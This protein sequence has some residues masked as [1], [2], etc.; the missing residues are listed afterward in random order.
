[1]NFKDKVALITGASRGIGAAIA[2]DLASH[3]CNI[4]INYNN[5]EEE[6]NKLKDKIE[7]EFKVKV[8]II[9]ADITKENEII[10][11][12]NNVIKEFGKI[13]ILVNNAGIA[14]DSA[15]EDKNI[16]SF[17][18]I[19]D[20]NLI[21]P[22]LISREVAKYMVSQK[23]GSIINISSTNGL[24]AYY[25]YSLD[26]DASKAGLISL[27][28]NLSEMFAPYI[29]VNALAPG[30]VNTDMNKE[31]DEEYIKEEEK[32]IYLNRFANPDEIAKV[33]TFLASPDASYIN[34]E[35]IRVDG[36]TR[37]A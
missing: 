30:W 37:H 21:G 31:L 22:F 25:S 17:H 12:V 24:D 2:Y 1:M 7:K 13:D 18:K 28:H 15:I 8:L 14:I 9:K 5:S 26:Y 11:M 27:T 32:N 29:R 19:L 16:D 10:N 34:N 20:T 35:V 6:A 36:G 33:V 3:N 23:E 4:C